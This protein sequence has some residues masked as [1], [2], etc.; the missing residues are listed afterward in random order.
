MASFP[1]SGLKKQL[2]KANQFMTERITGVEGTKLDTEFQEMERRTGVNFINVLC[3]P[4]LYDSLWAAF[5]YLLFGFEFFGANFLYKNCMHKTLMNL[6]TGHLFNNILQPPFSNTNTFYKA[7]LYSQFD[8]VIF[9]Q[10][11]ISAKAA[12]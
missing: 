1:F 11:I 8:F 2:N 6:T 7:F 4:F 5:F 3:A 9:R 10:K 12:Q